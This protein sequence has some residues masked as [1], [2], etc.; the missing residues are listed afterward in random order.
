MAY[1]ASMTP[2]HLPAENLV[3][4]A[5][6]EPA[7]SRLSIEC[8]TT[9]SFSRMEPRARFELAFPEYRSGASPTMLTGLEILEPMERIE[10]SS[11]AYH[12]TALPLSYIGW[13][14]RGY[15]KPRPP[16]YEC[17]ALPLE[18]LRHGAGAENRTPL[19]GLA[20]RC[21]AN[22]PHPQKVLERTEIIE[23]SSLGWRPRAQPIYHA[24][25]YITSVMLFSCQRPASRYTSTESLLGQ[26]ELDK[27]PQIT[28][29]TKKAGGPFWWPPAS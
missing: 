24:R 15:S 14:Q 18:L 22:R 10:R 20:I 16:R 11:V 13:S 25:S 12:A 7:A 27:M 1:E 19:I 2:V 17:G 9:L 8:S 29:K 23:I 21:P 6:V 26:S 4:E 28:D 3:R 5:G